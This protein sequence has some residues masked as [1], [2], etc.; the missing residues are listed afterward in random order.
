MPY[1]AGRMG[2][3]LFIVCAALV[4]VFGVVGR[5]TYEQMQSPT[6]AQAQGSQ[7]LYNCDDFATQEEAQ[8]V[9][10]QHPSD[11]YGLDGPIGEAS[12]GEAGVACEELLDDTGTTDDTTTTGPSEQYDDGSG[13]RPGDLMKSG[14]SGPG[15]V[16]T[17]PDGS[18]IPDYPNKRNGYCY[19]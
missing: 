9:Y 19:R 11:P 18:C 5:I 4:V 13:D 2:S 3:R 6:P 14:A 15:P 16:L 8:A 10:D 12:D 1:N 7:D 17:L